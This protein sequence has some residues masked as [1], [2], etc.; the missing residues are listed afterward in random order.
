[1]CSKKLNKIQKEGEGKWS[2]DRYV[3]S[4][5]HPAHEISQAP[6]P[7]VPAQPRWAWGSGRIQGPGWGPASARGANL[8][9]LQPRSLSTP[10][11]A[12]LDAMRGLTAPS[13]GIRDRVSA[14]SSART[15]ARAPGEGAR[16]LR[17]GGEAP[18]PHAARPGGGRA[19][20]PRGGV[21]ASTPAPSPPRHSITQCLHLRGA[22]QWPESGGFRE[23]MR[24]PIWA[25]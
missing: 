7:L 17:G 1:M 5:Q 3:E 16:P 19:A 18:G 12:Q 23:R 2:K 9:N 13:P 24:G 8:W 22:L 4:S 10:L 14:A 20:A 6:G 21:R 11:P 25:N 15:A